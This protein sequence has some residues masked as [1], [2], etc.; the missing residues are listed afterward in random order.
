MNSSE[1]LYQEFKKKKIDYHLL[2][3]DLFDA[4]TPVQDRYKNQSMYQHQNQY[5]EFTWTS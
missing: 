3:L 2:P 5:P 1:N 4:A